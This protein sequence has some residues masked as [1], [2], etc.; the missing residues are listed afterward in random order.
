MSFFW[1][2]SSIFVSYLTRFIHCTY[3]SSLMG[4]PEIV[5]ENAGSDSAAFRLWTVLIPPHTTPITITSRTASK[6]CC[7]L[8]F[9]F[10]VFSPVTYSVKSHVPS[11]WISIK[12]KC[13]IAHLHTCN[14][15]WHIFLVSINESKFPC[16]RRHGNLKLYTVKRE[17]SFLSPLSYRFFPKK[18]CL[19]RPLFP[20]FLYNSEH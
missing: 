4:T 19:F 9:S 6:R 20:L 17:K 1:P 12:R 13:A 16:R 11:T 3:S 7:F 2:F 14:Y 18:T 8:F 15:Q 5:S 10:S